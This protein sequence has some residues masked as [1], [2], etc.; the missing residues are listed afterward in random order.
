MLPVALKRWLRASIDTYTPA[1]LINA[2]M[3]LTTGSLIM[4]KLADY[5]AASHDL[6][7][8]ALFESETV[9][10]PAPVFADV[11]RFSEPSA[12]R[13]VWVKSTTGLHPSFV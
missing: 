10:S 5:Q 2:E 11:S 7:S 12:T 3:A 13:M 6:I 9:A 1:T 8:M 4:N